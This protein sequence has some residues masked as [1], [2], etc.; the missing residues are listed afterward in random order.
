MDS[1]SN[2]RQLTALFVPHATH[3]VVTI[4]E[5]DMTKKIGGEARLDSVAFNPDCAATRG[6][7]W[8]M[9]LARSKESGVPISQSA[10][11]SYAPKGMA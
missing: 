9:L 7:V 10:R 8:D 2:S 6:K 11:H 3:P 5:Q 1:S 4:I